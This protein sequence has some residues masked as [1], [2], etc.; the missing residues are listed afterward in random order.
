[1][2]SAAPGDSARFARATS[3]LTAGDSRGA[4][5]THVRGGDSDAERAGGRGVLAYSCRAGGRA[6]VHASDTEGHA[7]LGKGR[8]ACTG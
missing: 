2:A 8:P 3:S 4:C 5:E 1:M 6:G 7:C